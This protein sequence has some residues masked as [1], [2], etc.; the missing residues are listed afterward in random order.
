MKRGIFLFC[1]CLLAVVLNTDATAGYDD[2]FETIE[3]SSR[4][5]LFAQFH[6]IA[7]YGDAA[8]NPGCDSKKSFPQNQENYIYEQ[9]LDKKNHKI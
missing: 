3:N 7:Y 1:L 9:I 5:A 8:Y 4:M 6:P 2:G